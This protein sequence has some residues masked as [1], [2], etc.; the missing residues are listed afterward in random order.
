MRAPEAWAWSNTLGEGIVVAQPDTGVAAHPEI[1]PGALR[2]DLATNI[3]DGTRDPT[4]PLNRR[5]ANP[6]HGTATASVVVSRKPGQVTGTAPGASLVPIRCIEDVKIFDGTPVAAAVLHGIEVGAHVITMSLGGLPSMS[7]SAAIDEAVRE[8]IIVLAAAGNCVGFVVFPAAYDAVIAVAGVDSNDR[9]WKGSSA[10]GSVAISAPA[11]NVYVARRTPADQG[12]G[13]VSGG[14]GTSFAVA[15]VAGVAALWLAHFGRDAVIREADSRGTTVQALF[16]SALTATARRPVR[17]NP[18]K[19]GAGIVDAE[20]LLK[21]ALSAI[22]E[23]A[24]MIEAAPQPG[25]EPGSA[26]AEVARI[27]ASAAEGAMEGEFDWHRYG[28]EAAYLAADHVR[29]SGSASISLEAVGRPRPSDGLAAK[30]PAILRHMLQSKGAHLASPIP[31]ESVRRNTVQILGRDFSA[32]VESTEASRAHLEGAGLKNLMTTVER[33]DSLMRQSSEISSESHATRLGLLDNGE[34]VV[35]ELLKNG[36]ASLA[37]D[38]RVT[39]EALVRLKGRPAFKVT[40]SAIVMDEAKLTDWGGTFMLA[41]QWIKPLVQA[42]GRIDLNHD[43]VGTG[44]VVGDG[45][46]MTN[47]HVLEAIADLVSGPNAPEQWLL[48][49]AVTINFDDRGRGSKHR[50]AAKSVVAAGP[51]EIARRVDFRHL[52]MAVLEVGT[53]AMVAEGNARA[54]LPA[55]LPIL[56]DEADGESATDVLVVGYPARPGLDA[57]IDPDTKEHSDDIQKKLSMIFGLDFSRKYLSPGRIVDTAG[58]FADDTK[59]WV[60]S[61][62]ATTLGGNSGSVVVALTDGLPAL[63]LHFAGRPLTANYCHSIGAVK[64]SRALPTAFDKIK[65]R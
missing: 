34:R 48:R 58:S 62:D 39:L 8:G 27:F 29:R 42:V 61:H 7:L 5:T 16:R 11:E 18:N 56:C 17:W 44:F 14:Q 13:T 33:W 52:D 35:N 25:A 26:E 6:G 20:A 1:D 65:C 28:A 63:A 59:K 21:L 32:G 24:G 49:D 51:D 57:F 54:K 36:E 15:T 43:H 37:L 50:F 64:A 46:V 41:E 10:G 12:V 23:T 40:D 53:E 9:P 2:L 47:R 45:L 38:D 60:M 3:I 22:P 19:F 30:A 4:D 55:A 31:A